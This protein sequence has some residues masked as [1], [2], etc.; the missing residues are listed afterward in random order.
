MSQCVPP[1]TFLFT[2]LTC[3]WSLKWLC[4]KPWIWAWEAHQL[5]CSHA[6]RISSPIILMS[7]AS[8]TQVRHRW[9]ALLSVA[10]S[11]RHSQLSHSHDPEPDL[12]SAKDSER[13]WASLFCPH[14]HSGDKLWDQFSHAHTLRARSHHDSP[15]PTPIIRLWC[16]G[17]V[18]G[19]FSYSNDHKAISPTCCRWQEARRDVSPLCPCYCTTEKWQ[20]QSSPM[21][22]PSGRLTSTPTTKVSSTLLPLEM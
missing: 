2:L 10:A 15:T 4:P 7:M 9:D 13:K 3:K 21:L 12:L 16:P 6:L 19:M 18:Q 22:M 1:Y 17:E 14:W 20:S 8:S 5:L 11:Q